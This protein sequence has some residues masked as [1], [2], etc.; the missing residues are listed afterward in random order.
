MIQTKAGDLIL[1]HG[2]AGSLYLKGLKLGHESGSVD[3]AQGDV[4]RDREFMADREAKAK[5]LADIWSDSMVKGGEA[6]VRQYLG[7]FSRRDGDAPDIKLADKFVSEN[8][9]RVMWQQLMKD[10]PGVFFYSDEDDVSGTG[11]SRGDQRH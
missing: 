7:L 10:E 6:I 5:T 4:N 3:L 1:D 2:F 8:S 9:T 11:D